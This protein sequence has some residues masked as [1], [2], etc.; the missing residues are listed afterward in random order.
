[1][2]EELKKLYQQV[3]LRHNK[4]PYH[5]AKKEDAD[6]IVQACNPVC[7]DKFTLY[8]K[9]SDNR[10][11]EVW[12]HGYGC[13]I[14]K[15][16]TSVLAQRLEGKTITEFEAICDRFFRYVQPNEPEPS[17]DRDETFAAFMGARDFPGRLQCV[18]LSWDSLRAF[19]ADRP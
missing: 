14:S 2:R 4:E 10:I 17:G 9:L 13:A 3:I 1:M 6:L 16:S 5:Y 18:T 15:A 7:G 19:L 12:F 8:L 11:T